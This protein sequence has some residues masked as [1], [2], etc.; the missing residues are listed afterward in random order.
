[1]NVI[2]IGGQRLAIVGCSDLEAVQIARALSLAS[3]EPVFI[4]KQNPLDFIEA[5]SRE[6]FI[7][8]TDELLLSTVDDYEYEPHVIPKSYR[9]NVR[10]FLVRKPRFK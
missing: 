5:N 6:E 7:E 9:Q 3:N 10:D 2:N 4:E 8:I 1:M